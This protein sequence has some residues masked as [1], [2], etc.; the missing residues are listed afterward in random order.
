[1]GRSTQLHAA[2]SH[3]LCAH[4]S[5]RMHT[6]HAAWPC[7]VQLPTPARPGSASASAGAATAAAGSAAGALVGLL[8][9]E[10][11]IAQNGAPGLAMA[12]DGSDSDCDVRDEVM[13][14][15]KPIFIVSD[16][17]GAATAPTTQPCSPPSID[18]RGWCCLHLSEVHFSVA[19]HH[20]P[21]CMFV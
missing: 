19:R 15:P 1:M 18:G 12:G 4:H 21:G 14:V 11:L 10:E 8:S 20:A 3:R 16:C 13:V 9:R 2:C 17:T 7:L 6:P 5:P